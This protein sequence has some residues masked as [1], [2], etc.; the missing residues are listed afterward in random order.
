[1][2]DQLWLTVHMVGSVATLIMFVI[3]AVRV[4]R[5]GSKR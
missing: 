5:Q 4:R 3:Y 1:M 2:S